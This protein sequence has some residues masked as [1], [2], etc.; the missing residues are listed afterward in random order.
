LQ[1]LFCTSAKTGYNGRVK[2]TLSIAAYLLV[3][4]LLSWGVLLATQ[5]KPWLLIAGALGY[6][7]AL[8]AIGC[9]PPQGHH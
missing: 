6:I 5:G 1:N 2:F 7:I 3:A 8:G 4:A 9:R